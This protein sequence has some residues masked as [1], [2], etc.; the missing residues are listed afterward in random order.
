[1]SDD[2]GAVR[3]NPVPNFFTVLLCFLFMTFFEAI[4]GKQDRPAFVHDFIHVT[5]FDIF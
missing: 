4:E 2:T 5:A 1:M 3:Q